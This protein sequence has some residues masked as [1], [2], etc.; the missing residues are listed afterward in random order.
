MRNDPLQ[1]G[2]PLRGADI[3]FA[4][5][6]EAVPPAGSPFTADRRYLV[7]GFLRPA[8]SRIV[9]ASLSPR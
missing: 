8:G 6:S 7:S 2:L 3:V 1:V 9:R 5:D 4:V